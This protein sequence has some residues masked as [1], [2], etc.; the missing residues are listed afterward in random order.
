M[1][2]DNSALYLLTTNTKYIHPA[3]H[4]VP[5]NQNCRPQPSIQCTPSALH[6]SSTMDVWV[7]TKRP[8]SHMSPP[9]RRIVVVDLAP[10]PASMGYEGRT[11]HSLNPQPNVPRQTGFH[12]KSPNVTS[13]GLSHATSPGLPYPT[14]CCCQRWKRLP[15]AASVIMHS[16]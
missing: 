2:K 16:L 13:L 4:C 6:P 5:F 11:T 10:R 3:T 15:M 9:T 14:S 12:H 7:I 8:D 1:R